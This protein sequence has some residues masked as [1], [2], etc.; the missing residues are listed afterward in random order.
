M[1]LHTDIT[2]QGRPLVLIHGLFGSYENLGVIAR[3]LQQDFQLINV[4]LRNHGRSP[5]ADSMDYPQMAADV[6]E[7]LDSLQIT[8]C[9]VLGH[10]MGGKV[11][12][13]MALSEPARVNKLLLADISPVVN[14]PRH[15]RILQGLAAIDLTS[16]KD[17]KQAD[18]LLQPFVDELGV[19]QF[20][21]K[22]LYKDPTDQ[23]QWRFNLTAL[24]DN[25]QQLLAAPTVTE[26][27]TGD[28]LFIKG[29]NSDYIQAAHQP[30]ILKLFPNA[31]AKIIQGT[32]HWLH[33][34]K[35]AAF[36]KIVSDFLL[37]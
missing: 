33:A 16:L 31:S 28:T 30:L 5:R 37:R 14:E 13:Q 21:L 29:G 2:G 24:I 4:D 11:A 17:R 23:F 32:G 7:T 3:A 22:N 9:A 36:S 19:R 8:Q 27:Y 18:L 1:I 6:F 34:E 20:L 10:S 26:P 12:M 25:Y 15:Q 35:P